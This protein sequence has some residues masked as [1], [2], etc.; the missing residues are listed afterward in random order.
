MPDIIYTRPAHRKRYISIAKHQST[1]INKHSKWVSINMERDLFD[2]A[3]Y[4]NFQ[5]LDNTNLSWICQVGN[6]WSLC[7]DRSSVGTQQQQFGYFQK[8]ANVHDE[9]HGFPVIPFSKKR[10]NLSDNLLERWINEGIINEDDVPNIM[11]KKRI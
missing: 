8:P 3:D 2:Y 1:A 4:G 10:Y 11:N 6:M 7:Q 5:K 9:W